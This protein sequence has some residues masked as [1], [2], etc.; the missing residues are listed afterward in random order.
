MKRLLNKSKYAF[1]YVI[2]GCLKYLI[3]G[4]KY[5]LRFMIFVDKKWKKYTNN[6]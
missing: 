5:T 4:V 2:F 1:C 6:K 3:I